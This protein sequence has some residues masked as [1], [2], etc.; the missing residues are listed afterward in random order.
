[1]PMKDLI[2]ELLIALKATLSLAVIL[3]GLYPMLVWVMAQG[4]FPTEANGS[5]VMR[6]GTMV[7]SKLI[8]QGFTD[9]KY[10]HPRPSAAGQGYDA[11]SSGGSNLGPTSKKLVDTVR[12]RVDDYR[13]ENN[14]APDAMV[15]ADAVTASASGLDPHISAQNA[16]LQAPRVARDRG[17]GEDIVLTQINLHTEG[18]DL[19]ILG[20]PRVNVLM[21]NLDMDG[22]QVKLPAL[23]RGK[24]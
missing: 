13:S 19:G 2:A 24:D 4:L 9:P 7:G 17:L 14:L 22:A 6:K 12:Q 11:T 3:C 1:M 20:E 15:P 5:L 10:F 16:L 8:A 23:P 21:L 18:R